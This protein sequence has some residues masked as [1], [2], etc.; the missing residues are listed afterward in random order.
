MKHTEYKEILIRPIQKIDFQQL[1]INAIEDN[2]AF[3]TLFDLMF[4][5]NEKIA[6]R[7]SWVC[8]KVSE[9]HPDYFSE[10]AIYKIIGLAIETPYTGLQRCVLS[11]LLN[12][13]L[14]QDVSVEFINISFERMISPKSPVAVQVLS[15]KLLYEFCKHEPDFKIELKNYHESIDP[16]EYSVGYRTARN[17]ILKKLNK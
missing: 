2:D 12:I 4:D 3:S 7:A 17:N 1:L 8:E 5:E 11:M 6:W 9:K 13:S 15:M 14:P 10:S 16:N